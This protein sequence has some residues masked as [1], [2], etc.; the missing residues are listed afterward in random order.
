MMHLLGIGAI[1]ALI[2]LCT[3]LPFV[4]GEYDPLLNRTRGY[5]EVHVTAH[6]HWKYFWFD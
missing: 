3:L 4:P 2:L 6:P 1:I 5:Y